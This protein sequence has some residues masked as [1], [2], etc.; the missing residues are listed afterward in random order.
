MKAKLTQSALMMFAVFGLAGCP[1]EESD[2][3]TPPQPSADTATS[4]PT[5]TAAP[6]VALTVDNGPGTP[7][8]VPRA[9]MALDGKAPDGGA[10]GG[11]FAVKGTKGSFGVP[12]GWGTS[13]AGDWSVRGATDKKSSFTAGSWGEKEDPSSK[14][15]PAAAALGLADCTWG[16]PES[17]ALG[18]D[19]LPATVADGTCKHNG[20]AAPAVYATIAGKDLNVAAMGTWD[21]AGG[22]QASV[23]S[24]FKSAKKAGGGGDATGIGACCAALQQ[25]SVSAPPQQKGAYLA[26]LGACN[27]LRSSPQ[28]RAGLSSVRALLAGAGVPAACQ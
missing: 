23:F 12:K 19:K 20:A 13:Q 27:A 14:R 1:E 26:A 18:K 21:D 5:A 25:N 7:G 11:T 3:T 6:T 15:D 4:E 28:G 17:I 22:D 9:K 16:T 2:E 8:V 10:T 24:V